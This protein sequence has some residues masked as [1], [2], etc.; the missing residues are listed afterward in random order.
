MFDVCNWRSIAIGQIALQ[1]SPALERVTFILKIPFDHT[2]I[3][4]AILFTV[5]EFLQGCI[6]SICNSVS[7]CGGF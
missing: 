5:N 1:D 6:V 4:V 3:G 7:I 2:K